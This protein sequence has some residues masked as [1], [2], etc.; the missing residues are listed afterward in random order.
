MIN[1][2]W[3]LCWTNCS[4]IQPEHKGANATLQAWEQELRLHDN[5][6][7]I[8]LLD[9]IWTETAAGIFNVSSWQVLPPTPNNLARVRTVLLRTLK[10]RK[11]NYLTGAASPNPG[12][13]DRRS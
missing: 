3:F 2:P 7:L 9:P 8:V 12:G 10:T 5:D 6:Y 11:V 1:L 13:P 4:A